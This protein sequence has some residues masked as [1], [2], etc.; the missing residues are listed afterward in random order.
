MDANSSTTGDFSF[1]VLD[2]NIATTIDLD[3]TVQGTVDP[4]TAA[5]FSFEG[6][7]GQT[8]VLAPELFNSSY[9]VYSPSNQLISSGGSEFTI[10]GDGTYLVRV[11]GF[12][13]QPS[14]YSFRVEEPNVIEESLTIGETVEGSIENAGDRIIY[15]FDGTLGQKLI[16]DGISGSFN[17]H[18][19]NIN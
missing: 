11:G 5:L 15:T 1:R 7:E 13:N 14:D 19:Q 16:Y 9:T 18:L 6:T 8:L 3:T 2:A 17:R 12:A 4:S 10:P